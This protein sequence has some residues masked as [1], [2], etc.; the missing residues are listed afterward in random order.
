MFG[1]SQIVK[2]LRH[3]DKHFGIHLIGNEEPLKV[4]E[5]GIMLVQ[6]LVQED[7]SFNYGSLVKYS[8]N[9]NEGIGNQEEDEEIYS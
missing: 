5:Q 4:F 3:Y 9:L 6:F 8:K 1:S 7:S 2:G